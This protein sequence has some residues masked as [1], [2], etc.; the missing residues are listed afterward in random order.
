MFIK[1]YKYIFIFFIILAILGCFSA[2]SKPKYFK[3]NYSEYFNKKCEL[4]HIEPK[5]GIISVPSRQCVNGATIPE[6]VQTIIQRNSKIN[7]DFY[8]LNFWFLECPPCIKEIPDLNALNLADKRL[9]VI[10]FC[11]NDQLDI[12]TTKLAKGINYVVIPSSESVLDSIIRV[13]WGYPT[14]LLINSKYQI[15]DNFGALYGESPDQ[16]KLINFLR[17]ENIDNYK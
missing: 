14:N 16:N 1:S 12:D 15:L 10:S 2:K 11:R 9:Q 6:Y 7:V 3:S 8:I 5:Q 4:S 17:N 13:I